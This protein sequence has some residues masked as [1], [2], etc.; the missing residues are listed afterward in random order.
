MVCCSDQLIANRVEKSLEGF[1]E[2]VVGQ[3]QHTKEG[4]IKRGIGKRTCSFCVRGY[5]LSTYPRSQLALFRQI[6]S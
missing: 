2:A 3:V 6:L 4:Q 1:Q 5:Y